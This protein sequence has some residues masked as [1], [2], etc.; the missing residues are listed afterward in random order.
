MSPTVTYRPQG[1]RGLSGF[2]ALFTGQMGGTDGPN[3][4]PKLKNTCHNQTLRDSPPDRRSSAKRDYLALR[5]TIRYD[6][7]RSPKP[8]VAQVR[9]LPNHFTIRPATESGSRRT[10]PFRAICGER[11]CG[12]DR[13]GRAGRGGHVFY[14]PHEMVAYLKDTLDDAV[15]IVQWS[16]K[17]P[18][19]FLYGP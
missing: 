12:S 7:S 2:S 10:E 16:V 14:L 3:L 5:I 6:L 18:L 9:A 19:T 17:A 15:P 13:V 11:P 1:Y 8:V 4:G